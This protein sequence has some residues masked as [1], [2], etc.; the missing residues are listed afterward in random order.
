MEGVDVMILLKVLSQNDKTIT[1]EIP[2]KYIKDN[3]KPKYISFD[4]VGVEY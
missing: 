1:L 4:V 3:K 2:S